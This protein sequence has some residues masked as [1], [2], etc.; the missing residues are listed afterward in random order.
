M[1]LHP[2]PVPLHSDEDSTSTDN[3]IS[4]DAPLSDPLYPVAVF[5]GQRPSSQRFTTTSMASYPDLYRSAL[6]RIDAEETKA[7]LAA[8]GTPIDQNEING[9]EDIVGADDARRQSGDTEYSTP[10]EMQSAVGDRNTITNPLFF[11]VVRDHAY[12]EGPLGNSNWV[13]PGLLLVG[14]NPFLLENS[15]LMH[16]SN[17][18]D[19]EEEENEET[20]IH[21]NNLNYN[22][23]NN[24]T[25]N[26]RLPSS[27][28]PSSQHTQAVEALVS[29]G[30]SVF[31]E[32]GTPSEDARAKGSGG[33]S[34]LERAVMLVREDT[35]NVLRAQLEKERAV[36]Y[37]TMR[38]ERELQRE[39]ERREQEEE[40]K[41]M[42]KKKRMLGG[43]ARNTNFAARNQFADMKSRNKMNATQKKGKGGTDILDE[44]SPYPPSESIVI[45]PRK[46]SQELDD[47]VEVKLA[48]GEGS[49]G[50]EG[51]NSVD[52]KTAVDFVIDC[53]T[54]RGLTVF[55]YSAHGHGRTGTF[56]ALVLGLETLLS[57]FGYY[58]CLFTFHLVMIFSF[59][60][61]N[62]FFF[63]FVLSPHKSFTLYLSFFFFLFRFLYL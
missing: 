3:N 28:A 2:P 17:S 36:Q 32:L 43:Y 37:E 12:F 18:S 31:V 54:L 57:I 42:E 29:A 21:N 39:R 62:I 8:G 14:E 7:A 6:G 11:D 46:Y 23:N 24:N 56:A 52:L 15:E 35:M 4:T 59:F 16:S 48:W 40:Q 53:I 49:G 20:D 1:L 9:L 30:V 44:E 60:S 45:P 61:N 27:L 19:D 58:I 5:G 55:V 34:V 41:K 50:L 25:P 26:A 10:E 51:V 33:E 13:I 47:F 63:P 38:K 22:N